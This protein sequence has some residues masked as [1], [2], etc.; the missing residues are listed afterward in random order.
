MSAVCPV[1]APQ[2]TAVAAAP[3]D[4][5]AVAALAVKNGVPPGLNDVP[6]A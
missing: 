5:T 1:A 2:L 4:Q 3:A 6:F